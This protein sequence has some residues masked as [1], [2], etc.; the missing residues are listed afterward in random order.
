MV[1]HYNT[2]LSKAV[3]KKFK[4]KTGDM[5]SS[6]VGNPVPT[7]AITVSS[8]PLWNSSAISGNFGITLPGSAIAD[9]D[10]KVYVSAMLLSFS[11][12]ATCDTATG[13]M[14][15]TGTQD[16]NTVRLAGLAVLTLTAESDTIAVTF[17]NP[18]PLDVASAISWSTTYT[19]G[20]MSRSIVLYA[21]L[22]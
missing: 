10:K 14:N 5:L 11:K 7:V 17:L 1:T 2:E 13:S 6:E 16:G 12:N 22:E 15:I 8:T 4:L 20:L 9:A 21:T 19:V 18:I 3:Q